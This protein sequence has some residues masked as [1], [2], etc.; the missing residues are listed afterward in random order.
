MQNRSIKMQSHCFYRNIIK[1]LQSFE[2]LNLH[3]MLKSLYDIYIRKNKF[4]KLSNAIISSC[5]A[6]L[7][8]N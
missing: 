8:E 1:Y 5:Q 7:M 2:M 6:L 4:F 3:K